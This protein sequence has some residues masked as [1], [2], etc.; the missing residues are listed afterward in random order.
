MSL[1]SEISCSSRLLAKTFGVS[2]AL[3]IWSSG[4]GSGPSRKGAS[5]LNP[6]L[7]T[8]IREQ[9]MARFGIMS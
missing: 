6:K 2:A 3:V 5:R 4:N 1:N 9:L 7:A 8:E